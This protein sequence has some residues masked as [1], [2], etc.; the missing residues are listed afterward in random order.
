MTCTY[1]ILKT[2][3]QSPEKRNTQVGGGGRRFGLIGLIGH[4]LIFFTIGRELDLDKKERTPL[5]GR[6][7]GR[8]WGQLLGGSTFLRK[9]KNNGWIL[10]IS[11]LLFFFSFSDSDKIF[12]RGDSFV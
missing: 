2:L 7:R 9:T 8:I 5:P 4:I 11:F 6:Y 12:K 1:L 3:A 10:F